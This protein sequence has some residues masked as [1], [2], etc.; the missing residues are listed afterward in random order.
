[1]DKTNLVEITMTFKT[2]KE[3]EQIATR[4]H[5]CLVGNADYKLSAIALNV[6]D[7]AVTVIIGDE[8]SRES[9]LYTSCAVNIAISDML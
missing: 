6:T 3:A 5:G 2:N 7:N 4:I 9:K 1:M 8:A